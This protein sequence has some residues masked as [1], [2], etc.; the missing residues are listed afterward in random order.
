[1]LD[2][3]EAG[4]FIQYLKINILQAIQYIIK[5]WKEVSVETIR[6]CWHYTKILLDT[7]DPEVREL[8]D[9][10]CRTNDSSLDELVNALN[11]THHLSNSMKVNEFLT[12]SEKN[13]VNEIPPDDQIIKEFA[14]TFRKDEEA[15][16]IDDEGIDIIDDE[17]DDS[18]EI[19]IVSSSSALSNLEN[20][21]IFLLQQEGSN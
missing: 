10:V 1:M 6:N 18:V 9:E 16:N 13:L 5:G 7:I 8:S 3:V 21:R 2:Q 19:A 15:E 20:V 4:I 11:N 12:I 17:R 14:Y